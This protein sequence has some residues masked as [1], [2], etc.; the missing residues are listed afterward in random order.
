M[1]GYYA[2]IVKA[3]RDRGFSLLRAGKGS[4]EIWGKPGGKK[5]IVPFNCPSRHTANEIMKQLGVTDVHF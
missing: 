3:L 2:Q 5:T 4:H 1:N